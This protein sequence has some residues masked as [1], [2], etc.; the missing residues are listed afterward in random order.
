MPPRLEALL[1]SGERRVLSVPGSTSSIGNVLGRLDD[2]I[3]TEDGGWIQ[4]RFIV[5]VRLRGSDDDESR[6]STD[7]YGQLD[8]AAGQHADQAVR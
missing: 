3:E 5:E 1:T 4:K 2:W 8:D 7:E 6:S